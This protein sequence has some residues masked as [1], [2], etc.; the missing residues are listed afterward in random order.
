[1]DSNGNLYANKAALEAMDEQFRE[2]FKPAAQQPSDALPI[3]DGYIASRLALCNRRARKVFFS[4]RRR[5]AS[6]AE[7]L[8]AAEA[9]YRP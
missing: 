7:A 4:E 5:G 8:A 6:E 3:E 9:S 2:H 1:M